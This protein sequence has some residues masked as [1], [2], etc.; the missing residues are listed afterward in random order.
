MVWFGVNYQA[1]NNFQIRMGGIPDLC[2]SGRL[3]APNRPYRHTPVGV[4]NVAVRILS[5]P[6][7]VNCLKE[8]VTLRF[9]SLLI[10]RHHVAV[11]K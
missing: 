4:S 1:T 3:R 10:L 11:V 6:G 5:K 2:E 8:L 9:I 7:I